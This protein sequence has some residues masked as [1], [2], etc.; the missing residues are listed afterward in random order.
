MLVRAICMWFISAVVVEVVHRHVKVP[1][2]VQ[3]FGINVALIDDIAFGCLETASSQ[4]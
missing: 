2:G 3:Q 1:L 4:F